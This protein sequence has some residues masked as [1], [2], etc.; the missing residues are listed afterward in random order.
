MSAQSIPLC[1]TARRPDNRSRARPR[2]PKLNVS[3]PNRDHITDR[4][5]RGYVGDARQSSGGLLISRF[6]EIGRP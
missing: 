1:S 6:I 4:T 5:G 3:L 2:Y